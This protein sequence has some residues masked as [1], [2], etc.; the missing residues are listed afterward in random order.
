MAKCA[1]KGCNKKIKLTD[2]SCKCALTFCAKHKCHVVHKC[3]FDYKKEN[4]ERL[5]KLIKVKQTPVI[6]I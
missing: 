1:F 3:T 5:E 6:V 2:Y 4:K